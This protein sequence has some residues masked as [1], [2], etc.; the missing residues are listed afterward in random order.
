MTDKAS[1]TTILDHKNV[2]NDKEIRKSS[3]NVENYKLQRTTI[4]EL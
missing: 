4:T 1:K 3:K 2:K